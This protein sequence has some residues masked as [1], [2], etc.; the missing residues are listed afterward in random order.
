MENNDKPL[1]EKTNGIKRYIPLIAIILIVLTAGILWYRQYSKYIYT[2][3]AYIDSDNI[4]MGSKILGRIAH[5]YYEEG[6]TVLKGKILIELDS[7]DLI[8]QKRQSMAMRDQAFANQLQSEAKYQYDLE[9]I[10]LQEINL[11]KAKDDY[12]RAKA[13]YSGEVITKEAFDHVQ[14]SYESSEAQL[15]AAK[16]QM[17]VSKAQINSSAAAVASANATIGVISTQINNTRIYSP[18]NGVIA[19]RWWLTGDIVQPGQ[20][21]YT[22]NDKHKFWVL[23]YLEETNIS[24]LHMGQ[25]AKFTIDAFPGVTFMGKVFLIGSNTASQ[26]SLIPPSNASGNFTKVT[27]RIPIK[28]SIDGTEDKSDISKF[29]IL[30]GMSVVMKIIK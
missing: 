5:L 27:Q 18:V 12:N 4:F 2:D 17:N 19:K 14:K 10:K 16:I 6:D 21:I 28:I 13:Q 23:V 25:S 11:Q 30:S 29:K 1:I 15:D 7:S 8:A 3:D 20:A 26:F 9:N 24:D 22:I